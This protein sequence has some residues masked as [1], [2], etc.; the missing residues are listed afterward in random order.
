M[1]LITTKLAAELGAFAV[2]G[3]VASAAILPCNNCKANIVRA[4]S[5]T[6]TLTHT[7]AAQVDPKKLPDGGDPLWDVY[8]RK[9]VPNGR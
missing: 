2:A 8:D 9:V 6:A 3:L 7:R 5:S 4:F 1:T